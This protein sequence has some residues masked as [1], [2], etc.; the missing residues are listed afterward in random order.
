MDPSTLE[1]CQD[2]KMAT[3]MLLYLK[4]YYITLK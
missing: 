4:S 2:D 3:D 1:T